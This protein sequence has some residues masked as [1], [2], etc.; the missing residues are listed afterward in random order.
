MTGYRDA[1]PSHRTLLIATNIKQL[2]KSRRMTLEETAQ[3]VKQ[4][5]VPM[6][7]SILV[8]IEVGRRDNVTVDEL[9]ALAEVLGSTIEYVAGGVGVACTHCQ[10]DPPTDFTCNR[11]RRTGTPPTEED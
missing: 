3:A 11:C 2:R 5:G 10:D 4:T 7:R 1:R 8:N 9:F 6:S